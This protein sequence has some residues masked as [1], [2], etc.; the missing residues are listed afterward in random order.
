MLN[1]IFH[2]RKGESTVYT[3]HSAAVRSVD[4][5]S[6][7]QNL[8]T[9]SADKTVKLWTVHRQKFQ[10]S[11]NAHSNWVRCAKFSDDA[12]LIVSASDDKSIKLWDRNSKECIHSFSEYSGLFFFHKINGKSWRKIEKGARNYFES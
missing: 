3:A 2:Y 5:S 8:L 1:S 11:L 10:F 4:F 9:A 12:R 7:G 6:A